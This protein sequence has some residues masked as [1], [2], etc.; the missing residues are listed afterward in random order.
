[1]NANSKEKIQLTVFSFLNF[2]G[3]RVLVALACNHKILAV[4]R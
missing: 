4:L 1:M 3:I 2:R